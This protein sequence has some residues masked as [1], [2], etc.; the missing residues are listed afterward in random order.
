MKHLYSFILLIICININAQDT[1]LDHY[2]RIGIDNNIQLQHSRNKLNK[3]QLSLQEAKSKYYPQLNLYARYTTSVGGRTFDIPVGDLLNPVYSYLHKTSQVLPEPQ[4]FPNIFV[5]NQTFNLLRP[6]EQETKFTLLQPIFNRQIYINKRLNKKLVT[7][8]KL[9]Y[10]LSKEDLIHDIKVSYYNFLLTV[11]LLQALQAT[12]KVLQENLRVSQ[13]LF[14]NHKVTKEIVYRSKAELSKFE[15][16]ITDAEK[17]NALAASYFNTLINRDIDAS[18]E[19]QSSFSDTNLILDKD[20]LILQALSNRK[21]LKQL[22][23]AKEIYKDKVEI[24]RSNYVPNLSVYGEAGIQ[25]EH[26]DFGRSYNYYTGSLVLQWKLFAGLENRHKVKQAR[27]DVKNIDLEKEDAKNKIRLQ[28]INAYYDCLSQKKNLHYSKEEFSSA[29]AAFK[30]VQ[31]KYYQG[32]ASLLEF[33]DARATM[34]RAEK[35]KIITRY[36]FLIA[37]SNLENTI[38]SPE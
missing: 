33:L 3:A 23:H 35:Q 17:K 37:L 36:Q 12:K 31:K 28:V 16:E 26:Y 7:T 10:R 38:S 27:L 15:K 22:D 18:I 9:S 32:Q 8:E 6:Y 11:D 24:N 4:Q 25:G 13:S 1:I 29:Q 21:E 34:T 5:D 2:I 20:I 14:K 30:L 19:K